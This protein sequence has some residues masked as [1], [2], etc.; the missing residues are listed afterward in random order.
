MARFLVYASPDDMRHDES[1]RRVSPFAC[2][3][4]LR[5]SRRTAIHARWTAENPGLQPTRLPN[6]PIMLAPTT[7]HTQVM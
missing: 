2:I 5:T 1:H 7:P 6:L 3:L 4:G